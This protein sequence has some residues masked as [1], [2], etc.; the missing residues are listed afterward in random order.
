MSSTRFV[1]FGSRWPPWPLIGWYIFEFS[2]KL[3]STK[4]DR[5]EDFNVLHQVCVFGADPKKNKMAVLASDWLRYFRLLLWTEFNETWQE[6]RSERPLPSLCFSGL[7]EKQDGR[8]GLWMAD[9]FS[10]ETPEMNSTKVDGKQDLNPGQ[11]IKKVAHCT[12]VHVMWPFWASCFSLLSNGFQGTRC[13]H[14]TGGWSLSKEEQSVTN[15]CTL[16]I[17]SWAHLYC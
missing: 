6:A 14:P 15:F 17:S 4:L 3:N 9:T 7:S 11:S 16:L 10:S 13:S 1:F 12:Q 8:R 2:S 5:K